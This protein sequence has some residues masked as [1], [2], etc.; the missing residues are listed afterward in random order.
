MVGV[1]LDAIAV[2]NDGSVSVGDVFMLRFDELVM[3]NGL[4]VRG[5][6]HMD[7]SVSKQPRVIVTGHFTGTYCGVQ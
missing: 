2:N 5:T 6:L 3:K 4:P 1:G 7:Y